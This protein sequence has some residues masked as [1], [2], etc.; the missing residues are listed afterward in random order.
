MEDNSFSY[1]LSGPDAARHTTLIKWIRFSLESLIGE[2][3]EI[4]QTYYTIGNILSKKNVSFETFMI[5]LDCCVS[6]V[7]CSH[8][9]PRN[10]PVIALCEQKCESC[11]FG[12]FLWDE[13]RWWCTIL[14][15]FIWYYS[16]SKY[17]SRLFSI[18]GSSFRRRTLFIVQC[19]NLIYCMNYFKYSWTF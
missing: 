14:L 16:L 15:C 4:E 5:S 6:S 12:L 13:S 8:V 11:L 9:K 10:Q 17:R 1:H 19:E 2:I 3:N 18:I 7:L